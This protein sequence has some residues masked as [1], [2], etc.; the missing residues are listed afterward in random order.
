M[1]LVRVQHG[2]LKHSQ[3]WAPFP[4]P[5]PASGACASFVSANQPQQAPH[6]Y[7]G[8]IPYFLQPCSSAYSVRKEVDLQSEIGYIRFMRFKGLLII[9][10]LIIY[11]VIPIADCIACDDCGLPALYQKELN[12]LSTT[13]LTGNAATA[14]IAAGHS[15]NAPATNNAA[16]VHCPLCFNTASRS[17]SYSDTSLLQSHSA[18]ML[19]VVTAYSG[20][21]LSISKPPQ[22]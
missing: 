9:L 17:G 16:D 22:N 3:N 5:F 8:R 6:D 14:A 12:S 1:L 19:A 13:H 7:S 20:P 2:E 15:K 4:S 18:R 21:S 11:I 10:F